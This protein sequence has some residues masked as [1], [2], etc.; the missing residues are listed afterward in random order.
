MHFHVSA[1][2]GKQN[3]G[4]ESKSL[5][6]L[7]VCINTTGTV[8]ESKSLKRLLV[9]INTTTTVLESKSLKRLLKDSTSSINTNQQS[10]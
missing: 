3:G 1:A 8:L 5:K 10:F 4:L 2:T 9:C 6:R 7:L